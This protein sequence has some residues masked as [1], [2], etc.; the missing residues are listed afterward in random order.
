[1]SRNAP[2]PADRLD[3]GELLT[4]DVAAEV[5]KLSQAQLEGNWQIPSELARRALAAGAT[6]VAVRVARGAFEVED[7]GAPIG[8][9]LLASLALVLDRASAPAARHGALIALERAGALALLAIGG[10]GGARLRVK[11]AGASGTIAF[12]AAA[13]GAVE[14]GSG[15]AGGTRIEV[16]SPDLDAART[17]VS[18]AASCRFAPVAITVDGRP[19]PRGFADS[20]LDAG[21]AAP[22]PG[23][24]SLPRA[25]AQNATVWLLVN[26]VV[27]A[28]LSSPGVAPHEAAVEAGALL[29]GADRSA[30]ALREAVEP[31]LPALAGAAAAELLREAA[32]G[33]VPA[34]SRAPLRRLVLEVARTHDNALAPARALRAFTTVD[35]RG[36]ALDAS[37]DELESAMRTGG[38]SVLALFPSQDPRGFLFEGRAWILDATERARL[39]KVFAI[40][41]RPPPPRPRSGGFGARVRAMLAGARRLASGVAWTLTFAKPIAEKDLTEAEQNLITAMKDAGV[42]ARFLAGSGFAR[43]S[44]G[45]LH[46]PRANVVV[47]DAVHAVANNRASTYPAL[48]ALAEGRVVPSIN[49]RAEWIDAR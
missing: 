11:V 30:S 38:G 18:L 37:L 20:V 33:P 17:R 49:V 39:A 3:V 8:A 2:P 29:P 7:D 27:A 41:F 5:R 40:A 42:S 48:L 9:D 31:L 12:D 19:L 26:G 34:A 15:R 13:G 44:G 4:I 21:I 10:L 1:M 16:L 46:L 45:I 43:V 32:R 25:D 47:R 36:D 28:H 23:R 6:R 22:L 24:V 35:A 14:R